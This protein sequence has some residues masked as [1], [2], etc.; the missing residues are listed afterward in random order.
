MNCS[1]VCDLLKH[2]LVESWRSTEEY[3]AKTFKEAFV[4]TSSFLL[5]YKQGTLQPSKEWN[6]FT[7]YLKNYRIKLSQEKQC[8][9][10]YGKRGK[11][12]QT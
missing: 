10:A 1:I 8:S 11:G 9:I 4:L 2:K 7:S 3:C 12:A 5:Q 6:T